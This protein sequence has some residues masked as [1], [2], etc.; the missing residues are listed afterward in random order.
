M[1][2]SLMVWSASIGYLHAGGNRQS[3]AAD[4]DAESGVLAFGTDQNVALWSPLADERGGIS[5]ILKGH[6]DIVN[7]VKF[8]PRSLDGKRLL[9]TGSSD[10]TLRLW[11][12]L[13]DTNQYRCLTV[14]ERHKA[15]INAIATAPESSV[16]VTAASDSTICIWKYEDGNSEFCTL[17][18]E[19]TLQ[20]SYIP[21]AVC[22]HQFPDREI[23]DSLI[24]AVGG[25]K[26]TIHLF[27]VDIA[28]IK[29]TCTLQA[30]LTGHEGWIRSLAAANDAKGELLL[31]SASQDKYVRLWRIKRSEDPESGLYATREDLVATAHPLNKKVQV[32]NA[33]GLH[34]TASFEALLLGHEDWIYSAAWNSR[35]GQL[36]LLTAS[37]DNSLSIWEADEISGI[38]TSVARLGEISE[39]KGSTT[40]T[41]S[42]GGLWIGLWSPKADALASLGRTGSWRLWKHDV[43]KEYWDGQVGVNGHTRSV[44]D[45]TWEPEGN[46]LL[47]TS[48]DQTSRLHAEW[49]NGGIPT[50]HEFSRPQIH[51][52]DLNCLASLGSTRFV[53]GADE[54]LLR[55][56]DEPKAVGKLLEKLSDIKPK[57]ISEMPEAA[58]MPVLGLSNKIAAE[59]GDAPAEEADATA[60]SVPRT[61]LDLD[62]PPLEDHLSRHT[63]WP[64]IEKLYGHGFE[65]SAVA[66]THDYSLIAT[67]CK[68]SS[69]DHA[70]IRLF[71]TKDWHEVRPPLVAHTLTITRLQFSPDDKYLLSVGRDRQWAIFQRT[72][73]SPSLYN[74]STTNP[75]G[76]SRMILDAAWAP[77]CSTASQPRLF[78]TASRDKNIKIWQFSDPDL[79]QDS[80]ITVTL[81]ATISRSTTITAVDFSPPST[82]GDTH[83]TLA[84]GEEGGQIS[85]HKFS[86][87]G[88]WDVESQDL[89]SRSC[90]SKT[91]TR[92]A[93]RPG[94]KP[95]GDKSCLAVASADCSIRL[96]R[97][98]LSE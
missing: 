92:L 20:P 13:S 72:P 47:S 9:V 36:Q 25:T 84:A 42:S 86:P 43:E 68:A 52:Y 66:S 7:A 73:S 28:E 93:W 89:E 31:A 95:E 85:L 81:V 48:L 22:L 37:A 87:V 74:L 35:G 19:F 90:P 8:L 4:W 75:K 23:Q 57:S 44:G 27:T 65:I 40:A 96:L 53:S 2:L 59:E 49:L 15:S 98:G 21:L 3:A 6:T 32:L 60:S 91:V 69:I 71:D 51:G 10:S 41:G 17:L 76:H 11:Q 88:T 34:F 54:K 24:L 38:W 78:A 39:Q 18:K 64:E 63:L 45:L 67:A 97:I 62:H 83:F 30:T 33:S 1:T 56:F 46:Y 79:D 14:L 26:S 61:Q 77:P 16:F 70:V 50:W 80:K 12:I 55:V 58:D 82:S 94:K 29:G 5:S